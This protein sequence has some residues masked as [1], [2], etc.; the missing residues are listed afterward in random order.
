M[1]LYSIELRI[2]VQ[3]RFM[4]WEEQSKEMIGSFLHNFTNPA[5]EQLFNTGKE[6]IYRSI[7]ASPS[8]PGSRGTSPE[9]D[10]PRV[11]QRR[12]DM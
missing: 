2:I 8:P 12:V 7:S 3:E 11:K 5:I 9:P 6:K 1:G 10:S 4:K